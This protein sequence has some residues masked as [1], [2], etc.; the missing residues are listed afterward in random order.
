MPG[1]ET[2]GVNIYTTTW[3]GGD[4]S[5]YDMAGSHLSD[6]TIT[7]VGNVRDMTYD[8]TYFYGSDASMYIFIL[9][10]ANEI[11]IGTISATCSGVTGIRHMAYDPELDGGDGGFWIGNW[12]ELGAITMDGDQIYASMSMTNPSD[13]YGTAYDEWT[14][15]GPY[16]WLFSQT[17]SGAVIYQFDIAALA[18]TGVTH[19]ASEIPGFIPGS[20][21]AGGLATYI[22]DT[23]VFVLLANIQQN[24][25]TV[26]GYEIAITAHPLSPAVPTDVMLTPDAG[27]A[28]EATISWTCPTT[29]VNGDPLTDLDE[30]RVYRGDD[31]IYTDSSPVIGEPGVCI[32][33]TVPVSGIYDYRVLGFNDYDEGLATPITSSW[34]GEDIPSAVEDLLLEE[35]SGTGYLT[36]VNPTTGFNGG[37]FNE[38]ILGYHIERNDGTVF[39]VAGIATEYTDD[40][41]PGAGY[42]SYTVIP[43]NIIG[44]GEPATSNSLLIGPGTIGGIVDLA[45]GMGNVEDV[46]VEAGGETVNPNADGEYFIE[47]SAGTYDVTATL[48]GYGSETIEDV[49]VVEGSATTGI[50]FTLF[51]GSGEIIIPATRLDNNYPNPFNPIT[52][53]DFSIKE[54]GNVIIEV[55]NLKGQLVN[56]LINEIKEMGDHTAIWNGTDNAGKPVSSGVYFYKM[57]TDNYTATKK[58]ILMK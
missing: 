8:G 16:L 42:Y 46:E 22:N 4:F 35:L 20:S 10:L 12:H 11:H 44:D 36:W 14:Y 45:G 54:T 39:E 21:I 58:M 38:P 13:I 33:N 15:G 41:I 17:G 31:L 51:T 26:C 9:D 29:K 34:I 1:T 3:N 52:N 2:D 27:G 49:V 5:R 24:P 25:N 53:I 37:A 43:Y 56:T 48:A 28:L 40:T 55:Y 30:M 7:G 6:F 32:D 57:K 50:D 18:V 23:G 47:L 19:D